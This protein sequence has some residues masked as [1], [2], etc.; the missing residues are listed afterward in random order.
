MKL[1]ISRRE[2]ATNKQMKCMEHVKVRSAMV[3]HKAGKGDRM[4]EGKG[5]STLDKVIRGAPPGTVI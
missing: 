3:K 2:T 1:M 4:R 5:F